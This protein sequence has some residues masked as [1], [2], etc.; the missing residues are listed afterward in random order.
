MSRGETL[1]LVIVMGTFLI[2]GIGLALLERAQSVARRAESRQPHQAAGAV[3][4]D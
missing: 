1:Y 4:S 3:F 2:F